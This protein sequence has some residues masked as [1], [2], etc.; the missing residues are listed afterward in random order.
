[1]C[2]HDGE[3]GSVGLLT[4]VSPL[5]HHSQAFGVARTTNSILAVVSR[6][7]STNLS[8]SV[9]EPFNVPETVG[10]LSFFVSTSKIYINMV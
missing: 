10:T 2:N 7:L 6:R 4:A 3:Y 1:M 8:T 5:L 9:S